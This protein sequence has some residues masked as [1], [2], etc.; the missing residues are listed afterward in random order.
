MDPHQRWTQTQ[1]DE[2]RAR[3]RSGETLD[4]VAEALARQPAEIRAMLD[5]LRLRAS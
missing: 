2:L 1:I 5:R 3:V 4:I